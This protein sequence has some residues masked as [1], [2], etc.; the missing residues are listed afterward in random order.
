MAAY[1]GIPTARTLARDGADVPRDTAVALAD[2][3]IQRR[4]LRVSDA[5]RNWARTNAFNGETFG[6][7]VRPRLNR[8]SWNFTTA[9]AASDAIGLLFQ[10]IG[11]TSGRRSSP[12]RH[13]FTKSGLIAIAVAI[14]AMATPLSSTCC[15][16]PMRRMPPVTMTGILATSAISRAKSRK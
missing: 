9:M 4:Y 12:R 14:P 1:R 11:A 16:M 15:T 10:R 6:L 5:V 13:A 3:T 8:R 7:A 2:D